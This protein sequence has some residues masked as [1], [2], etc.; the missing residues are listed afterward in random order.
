MRKRID[1]NFNWYFSKNIKETNKEKMEVV[2]IPHSNIKT[3]F[4]NF[5]EKTYQYESIYI[6]EF[7]I[8]KD[9]SKRYEL[10]FDGVLHLAEVY[11]NGKYIGTNSG[12]YLPFS[13]DI[14]KELNKG[15]NELKVI[16]DSRESLNIPPFG[17]T[18]DYL[19]FGGIYREV[20]IK[21]TNK[22]YIKDVYVYGKDLLKN[23]KVVVETKVEGG[24]ELK[25]NFY[26]KEKLLKQIKTNNLVKNE[27]EM[28]LKLWD[29]NNPHIYEV[30]V[31]LDNSDIYKVKT[32]FKDVL[33]KKDGFYLN[34]EKLKIIGLNRHQIYP[35]IGYATVKRLEEQD[36]MLLKK[37]GNAV[38]TSHYPQSKHFIEKCDEIGLLVFMEAPGWQYVGDEIWQEKY[39]EMVTKMIYTFRNNPSIFLWGTRVNESGDFDELYRETQQ[40]AKKLDNKPTGGV[41]DF[42]FSSINEDVYTYNDFYHNGKNNYTKNVDE[43][44]YDYMPYMV[45]EF[46]GHMYPTKSFDNSKKRLTH[47][48]RYAH[49][50]NDHYGS[51]RTSG[52]FGWSF[53]DYYTHKEFGSGDGICYHGIYDMFRLPKEA[54]KVYESQFSKEIYLE[55]L[56]N[57]NIGD[58]NKGFND[59]F[60]IASNVEK[61]EVYKDD[62]YLDTFYPRK[63]IFEHLPYPLYVIDNLYGDSYKKKGFSKEEEEE[64]IKLAHNIAE[65]GGLEKIEKDEKI[66]RDKLKIAWDMY[67]KMIA[68]WGEPVSTYTFIGYRGNE[69]I[70][71]KIGPFDTYDYEFNVSNTKLVIDDT[72]DMAKIDIIAKDNLGNLRTYSNDSF[73]VSVS[74]NVELVGESYISLIGGRRSFYIKSKYE[75]KG[76]VLIENDWINKK[77]HFE[78]KNKR[79]ETK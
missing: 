60:Y 61:I 48:L 25:I 78:V 28:D 71:K 17:K 47:A 73:K 39:K 57:N 40:I 10:N 8:D 72:Y 30:E 74:D 1:I 35:Y 50:L 42:S 14:T 5:S 11:L 69:T 79:E 22:N 45:T 46:N 34:G 20:Y 31:I 32:G 41:R 52:S 19:T 58:F 12:G 4:N 43:I 53:S 18:V 23:P 51:N 33:F 9:V 37:V 21:E 38:R 49:I 68:N 75:G 56:N 7:H 54:A 24:K 13:F 67:G 44:I 2:N 77:I 66:D 26:K 70:E 36:A 3:T 15:L 29:V 65:R 62:K 6:K 64:Y 55:P 27:F 63:D 16:V 76:Y 59:T